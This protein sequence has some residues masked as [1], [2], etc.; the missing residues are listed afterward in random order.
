MVQNILNA[1]DS[2]DINSI[3]D[4][5]ESTQVAMIVKEAFYD[6][7][8]L[9]DWPFLRT[10]SQLIGLGDTSNPTKMQFP[11]GVNK[12]F[13][14]KYN[15]NEVE[16]LHPKQFKD[17]VDSRTASSTI[18]SNGFGT[19]ADPKYW[20]SYDDKYVV[21]DSYTSANENSL[22]SANSFIYGIVVPSWEHLDEFVPNIP[23]KY[24][25]T[26][27]AEAKATCFINLKQQMNNREEMKAKRGRVTMQHEAWRN[28][29]A[30]HTTNRKINY[31]RK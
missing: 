17:M 10:E 13:W 2:D 29:Q 19:D 21:F 25:P 31:G 6:L 18:D 5:V 28:D 9:R 26:L 14:I 23:D 22:T 30:E 27:L 3:D 24:F 1:M 15:K 7:M 8:A 20:T 12:V 11:E 4:T 16:Y